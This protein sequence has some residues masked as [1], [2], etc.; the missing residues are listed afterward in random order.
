MKQP[1]LIRIYMILQRIKQSFFLIN[2]MTITPRENIQGK[3]GADITL[4]LN[5]SSIRFTFEGDII[6]NAKRHII[7]SRRLSFDNCNPTFVDEA[8]NRYEDSIDSYNR[9]IERVNLEVDIQ[10]QVQ[11][12]SN[13]YE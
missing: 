12:T 7:T 11:Q 2:C 6:V 4:G 13:N 9:F 10:E 8:I 1:T 5:G 3:S